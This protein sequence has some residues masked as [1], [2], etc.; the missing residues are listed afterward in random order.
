[1]MLVQ[2]SINARIHCGSY[3]VQNIEMIDHGMYK[4]HVCYYDEE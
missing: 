4:Y 2:G 1:M 3:H